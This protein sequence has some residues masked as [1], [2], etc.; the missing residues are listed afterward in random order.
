MMQEKTVILEKCNGV[1]TIT[2]NRPA[3]MNSLNRE[4][5][6]EFT[7]ILHEVQSDGDVKAVV[8]TG[9]GR[10]FCAGGD[11]SYLA[12]L[13]EPAAAR[14]FI[15]D[16][17]NIAAMIMNMEKP[18]V[19]MVNG[20]A[21]GAGFNLA[22]A[23]DI[24]YCAKTARFGQSF[25]KV[26]LVPDCGGMYLLPKVVGMH[27]AKELMFT[28]DLIDAETALDLGVVNHVVDD[29]LLPETV[30]QF[31]EKLANSAPIAIGLMK[32]VLNRSNNLD[33]ETVLEFEA[34]VQA[35]CMQTADHKE[36]V[37]A[38]KEKRVPQFTGK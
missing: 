28:A 10:A 34:D 14:G 35:L 31:A 6:D 20:V 9:N 3:T 26:G 5:V 32:R 15:A 29:A 36:G 22:L 19:A 25:V 18:V 33:L 21:A 37:A 16:A 30:C 17:G 24:V 1:A 27:K 23:C 4:L 7:A 13:T 11:L 12:S 8:L 38:F 2:L